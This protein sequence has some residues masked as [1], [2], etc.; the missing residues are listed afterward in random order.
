LAL[1]INCLSTTH[2]STE[3]YPILLYRN[4]LFISILRPGENYTVS[5]IYGETPQF[6]DKI[7][8][9]GRAEAATKACS[10][11]F[12]VSQGLCQRC[13]VV[14]LWCLVTYFL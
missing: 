14:T 5:K 1:Q 4:Y 6:R 13:D 3:L 12:L 10:Y 11:V 7:L 9:L 2:I 8:H